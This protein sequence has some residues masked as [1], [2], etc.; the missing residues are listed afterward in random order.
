MLTGLTEILSRKRPTEI[1]S[2]GF[3]RNLTI[4]TPHDSFASDPSPGISPTKPLFTGRM[5]NRKV[6]SLRGVICISTSRVE[7]GA[8][9]CAAACLG[10]IT[11]VEAARIPF[12]TSRRFHCELI[13]LRPLPAS[14]QS[15]WS[16]PR[17]FRGV[18]AFDLAPLRDRE[19]VA[20]TDKWSKRLPFAYN[21]PL[22]P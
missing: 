13:C 10:T 2:V 14:G 17:N 20:E 8:A 16:A 3:A 7:A 5:L 19:I 11:A 18:T 4:G 6:Q 9:S 12:K 1:S 22:I 15:F 21:S